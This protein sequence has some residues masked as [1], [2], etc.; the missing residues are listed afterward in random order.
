MKK[1]ALSL[2]LISLCTSAAF[3]AAIP[4]GIS[5]FSARLY[6][7]GLG[8]APEQ[9]VWDNTIRYL[10][11]ND[12]SPEIAKSFARGVMLSTEF[13]SITGSDYGDKLM[14]LYRAT[15][16]RD[17]DQG[18]LAFWLDVANRTHDWPLI[19]EEILKSSE[20][21]DNVR[22]NICNQTTGGN[23]TIGMQ[24][25]HQ[26]IRVFNGV[27]GQFNG[28]TRAQLQTLLDQAGAEAKRTGQRQTVTLSQGA[29]VELNDAE[30]LLIPVNVTLTTAGNLAP[31]QYPRMAR[32]Y[33]SGASIKGPLV[34]LQGAMPAAGAKPG[35]GAELIGVWV[36][37]M[38]SVLAPKQDGKT[39]DPTYEQ[40]N[41]QVR[42]A[43]ARVANN[44][45]TDAAAW[46]ALYVTSN[47]RGQFGT[48][49][50]S[51]IIG[52]L[53][54]LF[55]SGHF[56]AT[57]PNN[58]ST[59][60]WTDGISVAC[61]NTEIAYNSVVDATDVGIIL[62]RNPETDLV[63]GIAS[64]AAAVQD[65]KIYNNTVLNA[66]NS[67]YGALATDALNQCQLTPIA[68]GSLEAINHA[69]E[70]SKKNRAPF[71]GA[72]FD[73]NLILGT[74]TVHYDI[75]LA[76]GTRPWFGKGSITA[77][78]VE[79]SNNRTGSTPILVNTGVL[80]GG[81]K[82]AKLSNN[83]FSL[84]TKKLA[85]C[86]EGTIVNLPAYRSNSFGT[87]HDFDP[88]SGLSL[89]GNQINGSPAVATPVQVDNGCI[90]GN[91]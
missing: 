6:T 4:A 74:P 48:C 60:N 83:L 76:V 88:S 52:N 62:F 15:L 11:A 70:C 37:G 34:A 33:R 31:N 24:K 13:Q 12:C 42:G 32:I 85:P 54:T 75:M 41:V 81:M 7:D 21:A 9:T 71:D 64:T 86:P 45:L 35:P 19:V 61:G 55:G 28:G 27:A 69:V 44:F 91:H 63:S 26:P 73:Q 49:S 38:R 2:S 58:N 5:Q 57:I 17:P 43:N 30:S 39:Y 40:N 14:R 65:S 66:G 78:G 82:N 47:Y 77:S 89:L 50:G 51:K 67:A 90:S 20:F 25:N 23:A 84:I 80:V 3:A 68:P 53:V 8:R 36:D 72:R 18:G 16:F 46:S 1:L 79:F 29:L 10:D 56:P 87:S 59:S 22:N